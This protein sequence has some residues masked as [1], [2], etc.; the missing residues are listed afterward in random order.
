MK[1]QQEIQDFKGIDIGEKSYIDKK[2]SSLLKEKAEEDSKLKSLIVT[3]GRALCSQALK[4]LET[5]KPNSEEAKNIKRY[6]NSYSFT[7]GPS[8]EMS[9]TLAALG[10][11][12]ETDIPEWK[13]IK[14]LRNKIA[15]ENKVGDDEESVN[16]NTKKGISIGNKAEEKKGSLLLLRNSEDVQKA[17]NALN[18]YLQSKDTVANEV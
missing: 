16:K 13:E 6:K 8:K 2:Q 4:D 10:I 12:N 7:K 15:K 5:V 9:D 14:K 1:K 17:I 3:Y 18:A 11:L